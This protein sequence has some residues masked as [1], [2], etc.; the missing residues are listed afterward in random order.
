M[1]QTSKNFFPLKKINSSLQSSTVKP[2]VS[3]AQLTQS[4]VKP[5]Y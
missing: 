4:V 1:K 2:V 3:R 5:N